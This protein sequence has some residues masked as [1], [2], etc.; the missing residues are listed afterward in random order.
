M[1]EY[2]NIKNLKKNGEKNN[3]EK[4]YIQVKAYY[5]MMF[6]VVPEDEYKKGYFVSYKTFKV[7]HDFLN[8]NLILILKKKFAFLTC[9]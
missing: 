5:N 6:Y 7:T 9:F 2:I 4:G 8:D 3:N 1:S